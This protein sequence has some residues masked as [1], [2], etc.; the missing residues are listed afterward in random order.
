MQ[1]SLSIAY[2]EVS[3]ILDILGDKY[4]RKLP[5][6]FIEYI[7][8]NKADGIVLDINANNY[9]E[10]KISNDALIIITILNLNFWIEN[11]NEK[12]KILKKLKE[13]DKKFQNKIDAYK[14]ENWLKT[15]LKEKCET[16][17]SIQENNNED[18][19]ENINEKSLQ[20]V[21]KISIFT[22]IKSFIKK[23]FCK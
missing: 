12:N 10:V 7:N 21:E 9:E 20:I 8:K 19:N 16:A 2:A 6:N 4:K 15:E 13:N 11:Q 14:D 17:E 3:Q 18:T 22:K 5:N 23:L 1:D